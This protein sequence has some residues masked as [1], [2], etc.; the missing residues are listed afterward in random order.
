M[1]SYR[2]FLLGLVLAFPILLAAQSFDSLAQSARSARESGDSSA[3]IAAYQ[4]AL[5]LR[6]AWEEGLWYLGTLQYDAD[7]YADAIPPLRHLVQIAPRMGPAWTFLG[8]CEFETRDYAA[9]LNDL[10]KGHDLGGGDDPDLARVA[11]FHLALLLIRSGAFDPGA[12]LLASTI[13]GQASDQ[14]KAALGLALLRVPLLPSEIDPSQEGLTRAAGET[15][16]LLAQG[17]RGD[18]LASFRKLESDFPNT[19]YIHYTHGRFLAATGGDLTQALAQEKEELRLS[20]ASALPLVEIS[21]IEARLHHPQPALRAAEKAVQLAPASSLAHA[22]LAQALAAAHQT[23]KAA[24]ELAKA[25]S[26]LPEKPQREARIA[27][28]YSPRELATAPPKSATTASFDDLSQRASTAANDGDI[29]AAIEAYKDALAL[30]PG[31]YEGRWALA[32][33]EFS[34][35]QFAAAIPTLKKCVE[36]KPDFG[37]AWAMLG[38]AEFEQHDYSNALVHLQRGQDLGLAGTTDSVQIARY[39]LGILLNRA[40][41]FDR[42]ADVLGSVADS[43]PLMQQVQFALGMSLLRVAQLPGDVDPSRH[44]L[45]QTAGAIDLNLQKSKYDDAFA[46]F[47][48]LLR[49]YPNTPFLHFAAGTAHAALSEYDQAE[50]EYR[51][52]LPIS[53]QSELPCVKLAS[54]F[55]R[56]FRPA[57][58]L[59]WAKHAVELKADS[60]EARYMLGRSELETGDLDN[61]L[62]DLELAEKMA[63]S[64]PEVHFNLA[65][66]YTQAKLPDKAREQRAIFAQ[67]NAIAEQRRSSHG[68]QSYGGS[69]DMSDFNTTAPPPAP[70]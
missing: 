10:R 40:G 7:H 9:S 14:A 31:W 35:R 8:L 42:A 26:L 5:K 39:R 18:A 41:E 2:K 16:L 22:A 36:F 56:Q 12:A 50:A 27:Q 47:A 33:L 59:P 13:T 11:Q 55:L 60:A 67:L 30:R 4:S 44:D 20:P 1:L 52:E 51:K 21:Q 15:A 29:P 61:A 69:R 3:A 64:S 17:A 32:T 66:A 43:G 65:K 23:P 49:D 57:D 70:Q 68:V 62:K 37:T 19:P 53:P 6:P 58:A 54:L 24:A 38:L 63:P 28:L 45:F 46:G 25:K 34:S 48:V